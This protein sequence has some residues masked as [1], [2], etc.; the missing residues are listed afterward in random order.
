M[1]LLGL[2]EF[3]VDV[4]CLE[5]AL[6]TLP[7]ALDRLTIEWSGGENTAAQRI[8]AATAHCQQDASSRQGDLLSEGTE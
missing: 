5:K 3:R 8:G 6:R 2:V 4:L 7:E 1:K